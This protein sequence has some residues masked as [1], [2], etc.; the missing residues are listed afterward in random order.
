MIIF[1]KTTDKAKYGWFEWILIGFIC[2]LSIS[3]VLISGKRS[4]NFDEF[5][6]LYASAALLKGKALY[7]DRIGVHF[8]LVNILYSIL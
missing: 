6:V 8:P 3:Y 7:A 4:F 5:Q 2:L 1:H